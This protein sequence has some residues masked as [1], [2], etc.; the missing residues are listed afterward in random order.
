MWRKTSIWCDVFIDYSL[1]G[2]ELIFVAC[3]HDF[4]LLEAL[5]YEGQR[6]YKEYISVGFGPSPFLTVYAFFS[7][8]PMTLHSLSKL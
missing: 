1:F 2:Y 7:T 4:V 5:I 3:T 8:F 6:L